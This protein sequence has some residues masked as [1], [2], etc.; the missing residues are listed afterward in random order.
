MRILVLVVIL[1]TM[2][3]VNCIEVEIGADAELKWDY[4][5]LSDYYWL[6]SDIRSIQEDI[7]LIL[8]D[9]ANAPAREGQKAQKAGEASSPR[10]NPNKK[11]PDAKE[12][13]AASIL[14]LEI[15]EGRK[16]EV[17]ELEQAVLAMLEMET[18]T[19][20]V[21]SRILVFMY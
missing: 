1:F 21:H 15:D 3:Q 20:M 16:E 18:K 5:Y 12:R 10:Y 4:R 13:S 6:V 14:K 7:E 19:G 8:Y 2:T 11:M 17:P 9:I